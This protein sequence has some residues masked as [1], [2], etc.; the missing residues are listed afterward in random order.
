MARKPK[1]PEH[2]NHERW[3]VSYADFITLLFAF[4]TVLYATAQTDQGKVNKLVG[5]VER[6][7]A[8]GLFSMGSDQP[9]LIDAGTSSGD[10]VYDL[11]LNLRELETELRTTLEE[12]GF[13]A[14]GPGDVRI[15]R[16]AEGL[17]VLLQTRHFFSPGSD[18]LRPEALAPLGKAVRLLQ[19]VKHRL[20]IEGHT[21]D[22][23]IR[24]GPFPSNWELSSAR[25]LAVLHWLSAEGVDPRRMSIAGHAEFKPLV[26]NSTR[27]GRT[28]NRRV[29]IIVL[30]EKPGFWASAKNRPVHSRGWK[31]LV[32]EV[33]PPRPEPAIVAREA[34]HGH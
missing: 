20:R 14:G 1:I 23:P 12:E 30:E 11:G 7:F 27:E 16:H 18:H 10:G 33:R 15:E 28:R 9:T 22:T 24:R 34:R 26:P 4:F 25:A 13:G 31:P 3:L 21:D 29:E 5:A 17:S 8:A 2:V 6:A 19:R 32:T